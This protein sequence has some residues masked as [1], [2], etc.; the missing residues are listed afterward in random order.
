M[1]EPGESTAEELDL[2]PQELA[3]RLTQFRQGDILD[4]GKATWLYSPDSPNNPHEL[5]EAEVEAEEPVMSSEAGI[6]TGLSVIVSQTCDVHRLPDV[7]PYVVLAPL[8]T[9]DEGTYDDARRGHSVRFFAFPAIGGHEDK[10]NLALDGRM[11][12]SLEKLALLSEH[13]EHLSGPLTEPEQGR[14]SA[15]LGRRLGRKA[16][17]DELNEHLV[18]PV[19]EGIENVAKSKGYKDFFEVV[20]WIGL[21][22]TPG[23]GL[24]SVLVVTSSSKREAAKISEDNMNGAQKKLQGAIGYRLRNLAYDVHV[25]VAD[26]ETIQAV[27][28]LSRHRIVPDLHGAGLED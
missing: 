24:A 8:I 11:L 3:A 4:V 9:L 12:V 14:L 6:E 23:T 13:V 21:G 27:E 26:A 22:W 28:I 1:D 10:E 20:T 19:E 18:R 5:E 2:D 17:S 25:Y 7:E 15:F 16:F